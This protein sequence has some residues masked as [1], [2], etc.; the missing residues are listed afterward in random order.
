MWQVVRKGAY[1]MK[2]LRFLKRCLD[3]LLGP[4]LSLPA[5]IDSH[6]WESKME[7]LRSL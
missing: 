2:F 1:I 3:V 5:G 4:H 7:I 6:R